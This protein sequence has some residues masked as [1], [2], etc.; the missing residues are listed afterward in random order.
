[1]FEIP[2]LTPLL[3]KLEKGFVLKRR[4]AT[5]GIGKTFT[6]YFDSE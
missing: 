3:R 6:L 5:Q 4:Y 1:M 2:F